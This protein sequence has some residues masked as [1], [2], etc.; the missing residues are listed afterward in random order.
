[1]LEPLMLTQTERYRRLQV[2]N[3]CYFLLRENQ[4]DKIIGIYD[5]SAK[6]IFLFEGVHRHARQK[7]SQFSDLVNGAPL[8]RFNFV[9]TLFNAEAWLTDSQPDNK[10][11]PR[12]NIASTLVRSPVFTSSIAYPSVGELYLKSMEGGKAELDGVTVVKTAIRG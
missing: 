5:Y 7:F 12:I 3:V 10:V 8:E 2:G 11:P 4:R 6:L 1:M 9:Y